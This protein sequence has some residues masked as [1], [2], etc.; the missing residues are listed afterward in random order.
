MERNI[1]NILKDYY[2][3]STEVSRENLVEM[4]EHILYELSFMKETAVL[5]AKANFNLKVRSIKDDVF[6]FI[7]QYFD[8]FSSYDLQ[9]H[10]LFPPELKKIICFFPGD[11][12]VLLA[13]ILDNARKAHARNLYV[14][15]NEA[16]I[17]FIDDGAGFNFDLYPTKYHFK[18]G[19]STTAS[20]AGLGLHH[21]QLVASRIGAKL[22]LSNDSTYGGAKISLV[23]AQ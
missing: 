7:R 4:L 3:K 1:K 9:V 5:S 21:C 6:L 8:N 13:N 16:S 14:L 2:E 10:L 17:S 20:G 18:R 11:M 15:A 12:A 22:T 19:V 23:F